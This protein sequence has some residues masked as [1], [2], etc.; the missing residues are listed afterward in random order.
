MAQK[1]KQQLKATLVNG[2]FVQGSDF[3]DLV[4]SLKGMQ[5]EVSDPTASGRSVTF[6]A[7]ISQDSEGRITAT[8]KTMDTTGL[9]TQRDLQTY[10]SRDLQKVVNITL[11]G[12][13]EPLEF[14]VEH[15]MGH[16]PTVRILDSEGYEVSPM[17]YELELWKVRHESVN[18]VVVQI[19][20]QMNTDYSGNFKLVFD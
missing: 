20:E 12:T 16:Y 11:T 5:T 7:T 2:Y 15:S 1:T 14:P 9:L 8:K 18:S 19:F 6:I 13:G 4:D 17:T 3:T 10:Q